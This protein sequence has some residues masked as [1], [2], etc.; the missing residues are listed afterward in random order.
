M[1]QNTVAR[2]NALD[3]APIGLGSLEHWYGLPEALFDDRTIQDYPDNYHYSNEYDRFSWAA[4]LW[5]QAAPP[6]SEKWNEVM[7]ELL[8]LD[9]TLDPTLTIYEA[10]RD[11]MRAREAEW[12]KEYMT[13]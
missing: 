9:F 6:K 2:A 1:S 7:D 11:L 5:K 10:T 13:P 4:R 12:H 8:N 3:T